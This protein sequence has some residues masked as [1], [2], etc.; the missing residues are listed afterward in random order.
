M[1]VWEAKEAPDNGTKAKLKRAKVTKEPS[2]L[3][4]Y[5]TLHHANQLLPHQ[6][7][8]RPFKIFVKIPAAFSVSGD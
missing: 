3:K 2:T 7:K 5:T 6:F 4:Q 8:T 1:G